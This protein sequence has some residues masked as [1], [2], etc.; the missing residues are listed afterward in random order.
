MVISIWIK[1][2]YNCGMYASLTCPCNC[3]S[4]DILLCACFS[5][6]DAHYMM[7]ALA[8]KCKPASQTFLSEM[9]FQY[10]RTLPWQACIVLVVDH[11]A[12]S[13]LL[14]L[15]FGS[16]KFVT[17]QVLSR[18]QSGSALWKSSWCWAESSMRGCSRRIAVKLREGEL[19]QSCQ[20]QSCN[21]VASCQDGKM[22]SGTHGPTNCW[23]RISGKLCATS[24]QQCSSMLMT[25]GPGPT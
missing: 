18:L 4:S 24:Y 21:K 1:L 23:D 15:W 12:I 20:G 9:W 13:V 17:L 7:H 11:V 19:R 2:A 22:A 6:R 16:S 25:M 5:H 8:G 14:W 3:N 10:C